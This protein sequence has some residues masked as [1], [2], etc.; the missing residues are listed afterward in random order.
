MKS[1]TNLSLSRRR[2]LASMP[3]AAAMA[4]AAASAICRLPVDGDDPV[5]A[6]IERHRKAFEAYNTTHAI[7][8]QARRKHEAQR[9]ENGVYLYSFPDFKFEPPSEENSAIAALRIP[10]GTLV[11]AFAKFPRDIGCAA[12][13]ASKYAGIASDPAAIEA[14]KAEKYEEWKQWSGIYDGSLISVALDAQNDAHLV[15][16]DATV[17]LNVKPTS[18]AGVSALLT[19][20]ATFP[21]TEIWTDVHWRLNDGND[22]DDDDDETESGDDDPGDE[23]SELGFLKHI[24]LTLAEAA[25][26]LRT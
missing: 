21:Y 20:V 13:D 5:F 22:R 11:H 9:S 4:P 26:S 18:L 23:C 1:E 8:R 6:V 24:L 7:V 10:T 12:S 16:I 3:A 17:E 15:L 25:E 19:Y 2:L 14:W